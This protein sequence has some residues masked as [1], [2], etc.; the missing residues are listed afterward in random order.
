MCKALLT[1]AG[2][3]HIDNKLWINIR[4]PTKDILLEI[5]QKQFVSRRRPKSFTCKLMVKVAGVIWTFLTTQTQTHS[6]ISTA[7]THH[8]TIT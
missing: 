3:L 2:H 8:K 1:K 7:I 4:E 5:H 6:V